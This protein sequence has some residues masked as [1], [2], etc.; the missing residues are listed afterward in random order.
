MLLLAVVLAI[1][2]LILCVCFYS[3]YFNVDFQ[4]FYNNV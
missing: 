1:L 4:E 2:I 3:N